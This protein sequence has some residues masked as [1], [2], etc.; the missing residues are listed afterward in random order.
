MQRGSRDSGS[1]APACGWFGSSTCCR[2]PG[3][4]TRTAKSWTGR[5]TG[6]RSAFNSID[7]PGR[8]G[9]G[10]EPRSRVSP[11]PALS[12]G[13]RGAPGGLAVC[14]RSRIGQVGLA[15]AV[16]VRRARVPRVE[17]VVEVAGRQ[18]A[19]AVALV[20]GERP[21]ADGQ[22]ASLVAD[23]HL[24]G[25]HVALAGDELRCR[26]RQQESAKDDKHEE[27]FHYPSS[28]PGADPP[29]RSDRFRCG[30]DGGAEHISGPGRAQATCADL[31]PAPA[32]LRG[33]VPARVLSGQRGGTGRE[34]R[35]AARVP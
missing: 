23:L 12:E 30:C 33:R 25:R 32:P 20:V 7:R 21:L 2:A 11:G 8:R 27:T 16:L 34:S 17:D 1:T 3:G 18:L 10:R 29:R 26:K 4:R 9:P 35:G 19:V 15:V 13:A 24:A 6:R 28:F 22:R 14:V 31:L 5:A